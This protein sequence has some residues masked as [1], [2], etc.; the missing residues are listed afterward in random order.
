MMAKLT[1]F[2][3]QMS[4][5]LLDRVAEFLNFDFTSGKELPQ[6]LRE[7]A[8]VTR[9][10]KSAKDYQNAVGVQ[11]ELR[12]YIAPILAA[13]AEGAPSVELE[14]KVVEK[15]NQLPATWRLERNLVGG[16]LGD[17]WEGR[18]IIQVGG[19]RDFVLAALASLLE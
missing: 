6:R 11:R 14:E 10:L 13:Q 17:R 19:L 12:D 8:L 2:R 9:W 15:I 16:K 7:T 18:P 4:S 1:D 5:D 3:V